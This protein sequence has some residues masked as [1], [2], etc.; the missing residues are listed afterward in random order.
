MLN[1]LRKKNLNSAIWVFVIF[2]AIAIGCFIVFTMRGGN[3]LFF[4]E[5]L[6]EPNSIYNTDKSIEELKG[7]YVEENVNMLFGN[8]AEYYEESK[9]GQKSTKY[10]YYVLY[11]KD[12]YIGLKIPSYMDDDAWSITEEFYKYATGETDKITST[13]SI[14]GYVKNMNAEEKK[15]FYDW[16]ENNKIF[17]DDNTE[18][19]QG[20]TE[21]TRTM[22][23][24]CDDNYS[25]SSMVAIIIA[26]ILLVIGI[27]SLSNGILGTSLKNIKR[28]IAAHGGASI[29]YKID[30]DYRAGNKINGIVF[31]KQFIVR[32][33]LFSSDIICIDDIIWA[34]ISQKK[35]N[36]N[37]VYCLEISTVDKKTYKV[38][39]NTS[40]QSI[41]GLRCI[42]E[43]KPYIP[44]EKVKELSQLYKNNFNE[45]LNMV[46]RAKNDFE[47]H[48][49]MTSGYQ[50]QEGMNNMP[51]QN[52][53]FG[54]HQSGQANLQNGVEVREDNF[55]YSPEEP[56]NT[57]NN[58]NEQL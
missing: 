33:S 11:A 38:N 36:R 40:Q 49:N 5:T 20:I 47:Q 15:Y 3:P 29:E 14:S 19:M 56:Y 22:L 31:G 18:N 53:M 58:N 51:L 41:D 1:E 48:V 17:S 46:N 21:N 23:L 7:K 25:F 52:N 12:A 28:Y 16:F 26:G 39:F 54:N 24:V 6:K 34:Y 43:I 10:Q 45:F 27:F 44:H 50:Q 32:N 9:T 57:Y 2:L 8:F 13:L 55:N 37:I 42:L 35:S 4:F 30:Q